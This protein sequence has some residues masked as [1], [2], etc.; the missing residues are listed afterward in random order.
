M[1]RRP[2][3]TGGPWVSGPAHPAFAGRSLVRAP[4][5]A[6]SL[7]YPEYAQGGHRFPGLGGRAPAD[8]CP[9]CVAAGPA[10]GLACGAQGTAGRASRLCGGPSGRGPDHVAYEVPDGRAHGAVGPGHRG[11]DEVPGQP[12]ESTADGPRE[13]PGNTPGDTDRGGDLP[14]DR[15]EDLP[16]EPPHR[17]DEHRHDQPDDGCAQ[18]PAHRD[19][20]AR[21]HAGQP[22]D[23]VAERGEQC[24]VRPGRRRDDQVLHEP[25]EGERER[26]QHVPP[27]AD[28]RPDE[29][30]GEYPHRHGGDAPS[31]RGEQ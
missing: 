25:V 15:G 16:P 29:E 22:R 18:P 1:A 30:S 20:A 23:A 3:N 4:R 17:G 10:H 12:G 28:H 7:Y 27:R 6:Q 14:A 5:W 19:Y 13:I 31:D 8:Q 9:P 11:A 2:R 24:P 21:H 26:H